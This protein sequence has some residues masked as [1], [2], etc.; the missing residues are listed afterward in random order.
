MQQYK[1]LS[2]KL[3]RH[4]FIRYL[5]V[6]GST[7]LI[8]FGLLIFLH[9]KEGVRV[10]VATTIGYWTSV[11]FNFSLNRWWTFDAGENKNLHKHIATYGILL[12]VNYFFT[13][14]FVSIFSHFINFAVAKAIAV[15]IQMTWTYYV[16]KNYIFVKSHKK[17]ADDVAT[18]SA[19]A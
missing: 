4:H 19:E 12:A 13:L 1:D 18:T 16:Y 15:L 14:F 17:S 9:S 6:G 2:L 5:F 8:D 10:P 3:Y 11:V 7:F